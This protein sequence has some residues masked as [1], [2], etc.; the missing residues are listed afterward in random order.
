MRNWNKTKERY[1]KF[2]LPHQLGHIA[3]TLGRISS[4]IRLD[5]S[6]DGLLATIQEGKHFV[7]WTTPNFDAEIRDELVEL[8]QLLD[9]W[10]HQPLILG[11]DCDTRSTIAEQAQSWSVRI[12]NYSGLL[13]EQ[14][15][16][17]SV[18]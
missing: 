6:L 4:Q 8:K 15:L 13:S 10:Y 16:P 11:S 9:G 3:S 12:L 17:S 7:E 18:T 2:D 1:L 14:E 5:I